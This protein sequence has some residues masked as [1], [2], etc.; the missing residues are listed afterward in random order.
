LSSISIEARVIKQ[1]ENISFVGSLS[2]T[3]LLD[4]LEIPDPNKPFE[5]NRRVKIKHAR[6]FGNYWETQATGWI[7]PPLMLDTEERLVTRSIDGS[8]NALCKVELPVSEKFK[9]KILDGQHR[10]LGWY[11]KNQDIL[12]RLDEANKNYNKAVFIND[13][14]LKLRSKEEIENL[15]Y[16]QKRMNNE[17]VGLII[18]SG[19]SRE[20][21]RQFFVD[22]AK[23]A[24]GINKTV[25]AK[26]DV[27]SIVNR[28]TGNIIESHSL[29]VNRIDMENTKCSGDN[30]N[31]LSVV[32]LSDII[33]HLG[34]GINRRVTAKKERDYSD[35][36]LFQ[37]AI[38][39]FDLMTGSFNVLSQ[40]EDESITAKWLRENSLLGSGTIWRCLAGAYHNFCI[41]DKSVDI[42]GISRNKLLIDR[43]KSKV[44]T[45]FLEQLNH[46]SN[47]PISKDW[48]ATGLFPKKT[49]TGPTSRSQD[50]LAMVRLFQSWVE[51]GELF[52]AN[53]QIRDNLKSI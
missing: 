30:E 34:F 39:F 10:V 5:D 22:I 9:L 13:K 26:F 33:R 45:S 17:Q 6:E 52:I 40:I 25:Q 31:I 4:L 43:S 32:N 16:L 19:I 42:D 41:L 46:K 35:E 2:I 11:L 15:E 49:S 44:F 3:T 12:K 47:L 27:S 51:S 53:K 23:N 21:H 8:S 37:I 20:T 36:D 18:V 50:L 7:S 29:L 48:F 38:D 14:N 24:L 1:G 28:V